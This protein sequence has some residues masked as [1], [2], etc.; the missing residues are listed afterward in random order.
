M[1]ITTR[2]HRVKNTCNLEMLKLW[3]NGWT[4]LSEPAGVVQTLY[5]MGY[6]LY[7]HMDYFCPLVVPLGRLP[8]PSFRAMPHM[9]SFAQCEYTRGVGFFLRTRQWGD[10][11][12]LWMACWCWSKDTIDQ[13]YLHIYNTHV[14]MAHIQYILLSKRAR[15][16]TQYWILLLSLY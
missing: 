4:T 5:F 15:P 3:L 13:V 2:L 7:H 9:D 12:D 6:L 1:F 11:T 10:E 16:N 14:Q 8:V